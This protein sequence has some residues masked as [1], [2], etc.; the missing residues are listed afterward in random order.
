[1]K[2]PNKQRTWL[3]ETYL[4]SRT[5]QITLRLPHW[6][7]TLGTT[8]VKFFK[9]FCLLFLRVF[10]RHCFPSQSLNLRWRK[11][12]SVK[13]S[14]VPVTSWPHAAWC[15]WQPLCCSSPAFTDMTSWDQR[16]YVTDSALWE[17]FNQF[18]DDVQFVICFNLPQIPIIFVS[19]WH[20]NSSFIFLRYI[21]WSLRSP[22]TRKGRS[23]KYFLGARKQAETLAAE[24]KCFWEFRSIFSSRKQKYL[25]PQQMVV[26]WCVTAYFSSSTYCDVFSVYYMCNFMMVTK[27]DEICM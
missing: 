4:V 22:Q 8:L 5:S 10:E 18:F 16:S 23:P 15:L 19:Y 13:T 1:M 25:L 2:T 27:L 11:S 26:R 21:E 7:Q 17:H 24:A 6:A 12:Q 9:I 14:Q 20:I 3:L